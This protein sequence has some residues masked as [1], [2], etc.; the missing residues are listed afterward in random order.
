MTTIISCLS[1]DNINNILDFILNNKDMCN[2][3]KTCKYFQHITNQYGYI[4]ELFLSMTADYRNYIMLLDNSQ[5]SLQTLKVE[6]LDNPLQ[7][8]PISWPKTIIFK[9]CLF[10]DNL[11]IPPENSIT[12]ELKININM[13]KYFFFNMDFTKLPK[14]KTINVK[15]PDMN[16]NTFKNCSYLENIVIELYNNNKKELP[17]FISKLPKLRILIIN[18]EAKKS[19]HFVSPSLEKLLFYK[20]FPCTSVSK[21]IPQKHLNKNISF[22]V[23]AMQTI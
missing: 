23:S 18:C 9:N 5:T 12:E 2:F 15:V 17:E 19:L 7:W 20:L 21:T 4:R 22:S 11:L 8:I 14:L 10:P 6:G 13:K 3:R 1:S 16:L